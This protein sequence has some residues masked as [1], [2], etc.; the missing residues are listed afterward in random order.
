MDRSTWRRRHKNVIVISIIT[1]ILYRRRSSVNFN[2][3]DIFPETYVWK[4]NKTPEFYVIFP[5]KT[6]TCPNFVW[7]LTEKLQ[8]NSWILHDI[9]PK[10]PGFL[11]DNCPK[12]FF[13]CLLRLCVIKQQCVVAGV[14]LWN[15]LLPDT[16]L[17]IIYFLTDPPRTE[18]IPPFFLRGRC[19]FILGPL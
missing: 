12:I 6:F 3:Q 8:Q 17:R 16:V 5:R 1:Y 10:I 11:H 18:N 14:R 9:C 15:T 19:G 13:L 4:V 7:C 2:G